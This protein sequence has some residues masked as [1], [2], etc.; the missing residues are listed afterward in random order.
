MK[1][2]AAKFRP[3]NRNVEYSQAYRKDT[4]FSGKLEFHMNLKVALSSK[5]QIVTKVW[6]IKFEI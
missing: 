5:P 1:R 2:N 4:I 6:V 3:Q